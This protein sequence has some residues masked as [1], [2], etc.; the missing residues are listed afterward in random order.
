MTRP[1][2]QSQRRALCPRKLKCAF[3]P[4]TGPKKDQLPHGYKV[5]ENSA[6]SNRVFIAKVK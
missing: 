3:A 5:H 4:K 2:K 6:N 1:S